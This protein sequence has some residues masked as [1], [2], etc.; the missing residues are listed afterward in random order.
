M[1]SRLWVWL[2]GFA[3]GFWVALFLLLLPRL[4]QASQ[5]AGTAALP[6]LVSPTPRPTP[7]AL[8]VIHLPS[9]P[10]ASL[11]APG[12]EQVKLD[13]PL[14]LWSTGQPAASEGAFRSLEKQC[15]RVLAAAMEDDP[16]AVDTFLKRK[17]IGWPPFIVLL[18]REGILKGLC[19]PPCLI[20]REG[21]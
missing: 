4:W 14:L 16:A 3:A 19:E 1:R 11:P 10:A 20:L 18:D 12:G 17:G 8:Q 13:F 15:G 9:L 6:A 21:P 7:R 5:G 2:A